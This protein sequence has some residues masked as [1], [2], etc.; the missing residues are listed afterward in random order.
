M[1]IQ[2]VWLQYWLAA[3]NVGL[4]GVRQV[5]GS[6]SRLVD[7]TTHLGT[8]VYYVEMIQVHRNT[9]LRFKLVSFYGLH[10]G[11]DWHETYG[12]FLAPVQV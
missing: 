4:V 2:A 9:W 11:L 8:D 6:S 12:R 3:E 5:L 7:S 1:V 10:S